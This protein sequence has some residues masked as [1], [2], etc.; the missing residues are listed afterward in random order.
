MQLR[1]SR[2]SEIVCLVVTIRD[3]TV[4]VFDPHIRILC[5]PRGEEVTTRVEE[6]TDEFFVP[7]QVNEKTTHPVTTVSPLSGD[8]NGENSHLHPAS[9]E[10]RF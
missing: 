6:W 5:L 7:T 9:H 1:G 10:F 3:S 8:T 4:V 2:P